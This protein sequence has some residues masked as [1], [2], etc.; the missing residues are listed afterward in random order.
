MK[1]DFAVVGCACGVAGAFLTPIGGVLFA[2]EEGASFWNALL[3]WR[4]FAAACVTTITLYVLD[5]VLALIK[6]AISGEDT[7]NEFFNVHDMAIY[8]GLP[9]QRS[10]SSLSINNDADLYFKSVPSFRVYDFLLFAVI[11]ILAGIVGSLWIEANSYIT[12]LRRRVGLNRVGKL[13]ELLTL[14][15][16]TTCIFWFLPLLYTRCT[17]ME[18]IQTID[19]SILRQMNCPDGYYNQLGTLFLNPPG[20]RFESSLLGRWNRSFR[21]WTA[22][23]CR[24]YLPYIIATLIRNKYGNGY[25]HS[26]IICRSLL[27]SSFWCHDN[28]S[29]RFF[30]RRWC[31][32]ASRS[33]YDHIYHGLLGSITSW[34]GSCPH[35]SYSYYGMLNRCYVFGYTVHGCDFIR[36]SRWQSYVWSTGYL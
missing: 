17:A 24:I 25:L 5:W 33:C 3:A 35:F 26:L 12:M 22:C 28:I 4:S 16:L 8:S 2:M 14:S 36:K 34:C 6:A 20:D 30:S 7:T 15:I 13:I 21:R 27:R 31:L 18:A 23:Y 11:G 10:L 32:R 9:G 29:Y 1:R 19:T